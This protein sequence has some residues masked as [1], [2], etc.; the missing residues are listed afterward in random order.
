V[1]D[2]GAAPPR[3]YA[4]PHAKQFETMSKTIT[5]TSDEIVNITSAIEDRIILLEDFISNHADS[6]K[7]HKRLKEFKGIL[8]KLNN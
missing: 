1:G 8:A 6:P 2:K 5:L 3:G 4:P 7:A